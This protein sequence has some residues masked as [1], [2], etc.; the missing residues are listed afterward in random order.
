MS[1]GYSD[2]WG[3]GGVDQGWVSTVLPKVLL[4]CVPSRLTTPA[5]VAD[6][7]AD[8]E[9]DNDAAAPQRFAMMGQHAGAANKWKVVSYG[10][11]PWASR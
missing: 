5:V 6:V 7:R 2:I 10:K 9:Y 1:I 11:A 4:R 3:G 8:D